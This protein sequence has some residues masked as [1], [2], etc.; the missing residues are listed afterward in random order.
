[1][2]MELITSSGDAS[3]GIIILYHD[4]QIALSTWLVSECACAEEVE[5]IA[6]LRNIAACC[7]VGAET[8]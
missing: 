5:F 3:V 2:D 7:V 4:R 6:S 8:D 1:M